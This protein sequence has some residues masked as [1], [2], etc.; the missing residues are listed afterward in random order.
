MSDN[1][2]RAAYDRGEDVTGESISYRCSLYV[3][4]NISMYVFMY[5]CEQ[6]ILMEEEVS[7]G[8]PSR[9]AIPLDNTSGKQTPLHNY[10]V[11]MYGYC[12]YVKE[13]ILCASY[14]CMYVKLIYCKLL[15]FYRQGGQQ[16][17]F[18]F[19]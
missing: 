18:Q 7:K 9:T 6:V 5:V 14:V 15:Q 19:G 3:Y 4:I 11:C 1:D 10:F 2:K 12:M 8:F 16:F 17:H 13:E